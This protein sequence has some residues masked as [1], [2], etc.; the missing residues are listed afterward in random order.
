M[1]KQPDWHGKPRFGT[2]TEMMEAR[3]VS[4]Q[5]HISYDTDGDGV[6]GSQDFFVSKFFDKDHKGSL[7]AQEQALR[8]QAVFPYILES[9]NFK[10]VMVNYLISYEFQFFIIFNCR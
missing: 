1:K 8:D 2:R 10:I 7:N 5:P 9:F 3:K 4:N 6:V